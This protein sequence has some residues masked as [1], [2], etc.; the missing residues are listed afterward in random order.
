M[1]R[2][3]HP[4]EQEELMAYLDGELSPDRASQAAAHLA[5]CDECQRFAAEL[6]S[7]SQDLS[8]W[9]VAVPECDLTPELTAAL[10]ESRQKAVSHNV[11]HS[12]LDGLRLQ[13]PWRW[14]WGI[15]AACAVLLLISLTTP[16]LTK[17][18]AP[19]GTWF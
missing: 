18:P 12:W 13:Q 14:A 6:R 3:H 7:L 16:K 19:S 2:T 1:S 10:E 17:G 11:R 4:I 5:A 9:Q 15:G 8:A